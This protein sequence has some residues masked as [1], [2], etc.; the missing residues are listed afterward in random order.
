MPHA[1]VTLRSIS[2]YLKDI[3]RLANA[4]SGHAHSDAETDE[5]SQDYMQRCRF[6]FRRSDDVCDTQTSTVNDEKI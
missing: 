6:T 5:M 1:D 3:R 4:K 2:F